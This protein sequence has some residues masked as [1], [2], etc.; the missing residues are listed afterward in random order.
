MIVSFKGKTFEVRTC[1]G[2]LPTRLKPNDFIMVQGQMVRVETVQ[3]NCP[4]W[5]SNRATKLMVL[6]E[7]ESGVKFPVDNLSGT[8]DVLRIK[9]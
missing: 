5:E 3:P 8:Y 4:V 1:E 7:T 6:F 9:K 2:V